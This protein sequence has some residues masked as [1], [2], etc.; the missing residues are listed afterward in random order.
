MPVTQDRPQTCNNYDKKFQTNPSL[1]P[2]NA[3]NLNL[4]SSE[5][6]AH[7]NMRD[8][9]YRS[10]SELEIENFKVESQDV[11]IGG[12]NCPS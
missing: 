3:N 6:S 10:N 12:G 8:E 11:M 5:F 1:T 7:H 9:N 2:A 4:N